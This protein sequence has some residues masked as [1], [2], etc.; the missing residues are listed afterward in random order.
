MSGGRW[1]VLSVDFIM[2]EIVILLITWIRRRSFMGITMVYHRSLN[3]FNNAN[4]FRFVY[5]KY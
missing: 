3:V 1:I 4:L 5:L 2:F